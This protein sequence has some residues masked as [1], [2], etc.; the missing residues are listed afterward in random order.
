MRR[1]IRDVDIKN[2]NKDI[3]SKSKSIE[4][5]PDPHLD[6]VAKLVPAEIIAA[7]LAANNIILAQIGT[8][9]ASPRIKMVSWIVFG[10]LL[11]ATPFY[12]R[13]AIKSVLGPLK[14]QVLVST[15]AF[16]F[17]VFAIGGPFALETWYERELAGLSLIIFSVISPLLIPK[18]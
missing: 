13:R 2:S 12:T 11:I 16:I 5:K 18:K 8:N 4:A 9:S 7:F 17:W 15:L 6:K 14:S 1:I 10:I 3:E